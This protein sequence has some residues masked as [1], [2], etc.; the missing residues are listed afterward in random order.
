MLR[1]FPLPSSAK[2]ACLL[3]V[4]ILAGCGGAGKSEPTT[5]TVGGDGFA[6]EAPAG[7]V[8]THDT[9][10]IAAS[11]GTVDRVEVRT[12]RLT[13][14][15]DASRFRA[16]VRELDGVISGIASQLEG[17]VT[18]RRTVVVG[19][20]KA[21]SYVIAY[22]GDKTQEITFVLEGR[23]EYQ[24]L[25]RRLASADDSFCRALLESFTLE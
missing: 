9:D 3:A 24:L 12:F 18:S 6:F 5:Q 23:Q 22:D 21:R 10:T 14:P 8:V 17:K 11:S 4:L 2:P 16:A 13:R 7:W 15:Y 25:C 19:G 1:S 20:R